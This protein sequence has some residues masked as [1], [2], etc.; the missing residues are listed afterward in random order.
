MSYSPLV[1]VHLQH[2]IF[3]QNI[4]PICLVMTLGL[5]ISVCFLFLWEPF[6]L[7]AIKNFHSYSTKLCQLEDLEL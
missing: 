2:V 1:S 7:S 4:F 6:P 3:I 5:Q